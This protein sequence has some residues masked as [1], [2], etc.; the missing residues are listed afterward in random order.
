LEKNKHANGLKQLNIFHRAV[1]GANG[2]VKLY[3]S[4]KTGN[5]GHSISKP[6]SNSFEEVNATTLA[7]VFVANHIHFVDLIKFNCEGAEF[8]IL[9]S[10]AKDFIK[11]IG[12]AI[13][14]YH[15]DLDTQGGDVER[16]IQLLRSLNFRTDRIRKSED[17]GWLIAWNRAIYSQW[18][19]FY[20]GLTRRLKNW[21]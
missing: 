14:L 20:K 3:H 7:E 18:H 19:F 15:S 12:L 10:T 21:L 1:A 13:I 8:E 9:F 11:K 2:P 5:W 16:M 6:I 4:E 17:R